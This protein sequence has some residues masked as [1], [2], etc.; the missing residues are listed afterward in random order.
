M[1]VK[2]IAFIPSENQMAVGKKWAYP[3]VW[4][5]KANNLDVNPCSQDSWI[6]S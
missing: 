6:P 3:A 1:L 2:I 4:L 5:I